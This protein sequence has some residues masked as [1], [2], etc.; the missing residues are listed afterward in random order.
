MK[1]KIVELEIK[2]EEMCDTYYLVNPNKD[3][4]TE[5]KHMVE[6]RFDYMYKEDILDE[7]FDKAEELVNNIWEAI[8][9]FI[10]ANFVVLDIDEVYEIA[11]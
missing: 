9:L 2:D 6:H 11:Y 8:D 4:L 10:S 1:L 5:L 7:E 3:K